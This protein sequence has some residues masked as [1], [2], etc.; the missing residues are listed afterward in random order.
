MKLYELTEELRLIERMLEE[1]DCD[2]QSFTQA[3]DGLNE[4]IE[5]KAA[6]IGLMIK[7]LC[8]DRDAI[9][10]EVDRLTAKRKSAERQIS[11]LTDYLRQNLSSTVKT[12]L[13][14]V[15]I[16]KP[17]DVLAITGEIPQEFLI[18]QEPKVDKREITARLKDGEAFDF[19]ELQPGDPVVQ[20]R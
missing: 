8:S 11:W 4:Q 2:E 16:A 12:P 13:V 7:S 15:S 1:E 5:A 17:R 20:I 10:A 18:Y 3:L 19:A 6:N 9:K 14:T